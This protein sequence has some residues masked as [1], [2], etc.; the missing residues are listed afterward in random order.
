MPTY[1]K[2]T[3]YNV[4]FNILDNLNYLVIIGFDFLQRYGAI[5]K[6]SVQGIQVALLTV[7]VYE[8]SNIQILAFSEI[9]CP[10]VLHFNAKLKEGEVAECSE[11]TYLNDKPLLT[12]RTAVTVHNH[13]VPIQLTNPT[14]HTQSNACGERIA[15][16]KRLFESHHQLYV[17]TASRPSDSV[18]AHSLTNIETIA[19]PK[20]THLHFDFSKSSATTQEIAQLNQIIKEFSDVFVLPTTGLLGHT[21]L[22][23]HKIKFATWNKAC[24]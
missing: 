2:G 12:A 17:Q 3:K 18:P 20:P 4:E 11:F 16:F 6:V 7:P 19:T 15:T 10:G 22:V 14:T 8:K 13:S 9:V 5:L 1:V 23:Q 24:A 21:K